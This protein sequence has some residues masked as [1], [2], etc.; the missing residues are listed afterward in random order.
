MYTIAEIESGLSD[1]NAA[2]LAG[3]LEG[4]GCFGLASAGPY[5]VI[6]LRMTDRDIV[7]RAVEIVGAGTINVQERSNPRH[8]AIYYVA[9]TGATARA[10]M[11][12]LLPW[13]G[14]RRR[15]RIGEILGAWERRG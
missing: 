5:P 12:A 1:I 11:R 13:M 15:A 2:W 10:V 8:R 7:A 3:L 9:W 6:Q 4:E 14:R